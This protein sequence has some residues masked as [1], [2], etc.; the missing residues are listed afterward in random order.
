MY[1]NR[2]MSGGNATSHSGEYYGGNSN[3]Y[4][5]NPP[6]AG[7]SAYGEIH[8]RSFGNIAGGVTGPNLA[9]YPNGSLIQTG[10]TSCGY[11]KPQNGGDNHNSKKENQYG[12]T[13]CGYRNPQNGGQVRRRI[14]R[15]RGLRRSMRTKINRRNKSKKSRRNKTKRRSNKRK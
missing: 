10:G 9:V 11:I 15:K 5:T 4:Y 7:G 1:K 2:N 13:S 8:P 12:G 14:N 3:N 6:A